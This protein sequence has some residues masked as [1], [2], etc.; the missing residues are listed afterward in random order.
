MTLKFT[1]P[2]DGIQSFYTPKNRGSELRSSHHAP[3]VNYKN[4]LVI[5]LIREKDKIAD[6]PF[7]DD[8]N[9]YFRVRTKRDEQGNIIEAHYG[10]IYG[11]IEYYIPNKDN[12]GKIYFSYYLNPNNN[13]TNVENAPEKNLFPK[14]KDYRGA[15]RFKP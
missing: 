12:K 10:K 15:Y 9:Y 5:R 6:V 14:P 4:K 1:N 7:R 3:L 11:N 2:D 8:Q 13:D